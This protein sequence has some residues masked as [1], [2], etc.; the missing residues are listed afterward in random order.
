M[1]LQSS[2]IIVV[3]K[4]S[5]I[6]PNYSNNH[7]QQQFI[8]QLPQQQ[9]QQLQHQNLQINTNLNKTSSSILSSGSSTVV[10]RQQLT[11][12]TGIILPKQHL[13]T[14]TKQSQ[15]QKLRNL[16]NIG[17][18]KIISIQQ[19]I[20][21]T[22]VTATTITTT[23][24]LMRRN[25]RTISN[26]SSN[27]S[28]NIGASQQTITSLSSPSHQQQQQSS[29]TTKHIQFSSLNQQQTYNT[30]Q[31]SQQ[32]PQQTT[33]QHH[34]IQTA[35]GHPQ[36]IVS[37]EYLE[38]ATATG[39]AQIVNISANDL[40]NSQIIKLVSADGNG[41]NVLIDSL[42][43][44]TTTTSNSGNGSG[45]VTT[46]ANG[47]SKL[48]VGNL[49]LSSASPTTNINTNKGQQLTAAG[50][51]QQQINFV[52]AKQIPYLT[53]STTGNVTTKNQTIQKI[54]NIPLKA[55]NSV[56]GAQH[57]QQTFQ[58]GTNNQIIHQNPNT[59]GGTTNTTGQIIQKVNMP[60]NVHVVARVQTVSQQQQQQTQQ[61]Q[62]QTQNQLIMQQKYVHGVA[63]A[64]NKANNVNMIKKQTVNQ[65]KV[66]H[67]KISNVNLSGQQQQVKTFIHQ[68]PAQQNN[69]QFSTVI[70]QNIQPTTLTTTTKQLKTQQK[71]QQVQQ[72]QNQQIS[73][74]GTYTINNKISGLPIQQHQRIINT[75]GKNSLNQNTS[76]TKYVMQNHIV[77]PSN[78]NAANQQSNNNIA[79]NSTQPQKNNSN[80][81]N[82][83]SNSIV[84]NQQI[85]NTINN[86]HNNHN[87][88]NNLQHQQQLQ[89][90]SGTIKFV[91][92]HGT[93][94]QTHQQSTTTTV[95]A[96]NNPQQQTRL[97][98]Y[99][100]HQP[101]QNNQQQFLE[102]NNNNSNNNNNNNTNISGKSNPVNDNHV[103][104]QIQ[105]PTTT[106]LMNQPSTNSTVVLQGH[107]QQQRSQMNNTMSDNIV[108]VNGT[109]MTD[110]ESARILQSMAL[111]SYGNQRFQQQQQQQQTKIIQNSQIIQQQ[112][113]INSQSNQPPQGYVISREYQFT[114]N[115]QQQSSNQ[116]QQQ[117]QQQSQ[118]HQ[119]QSQQ[120]QGYAIQTTTARQSY[121]QSSGAS[122][123]SQ[124]I[125]ERKRERES[126]AAAAAAVAAANAA[127]VAATVSVSQATTQSTSTTNTSEFFK[128]K[129]DNTPAAQ[130]AEHDDD[131][132]GEEVRPIPIS[133]HD[134]VLQRL[135]AVL[136]DHTYHVPMPSP[137]PSEIM[138]TNEIISPLA[139]VVT[140]LSASG[141][142]TVT[143]TTAAINAAQNNGNGAVIGVNA[144]PNNGSQQSIIS[145]CSSV[146]NS[147]ISQIQTSQYSSQQ[148]QHQQQQQ[149]QIINNNDGLVSNNNNDKIFVTSG[150]NLIGQNIGILSNSPSVTSNNNST[151]LIGNIVQLKNNNSGKN[152]PNSLTNIAGP[153]NSSSYSSQSVGQQSHQADDD[154]NSVI[155]NESNHGGQGRL[156]M[157]LGEET[158]TAPEA[159][160][161]DDSVTRCI[162]D[163]THDDGYM[164]CCDKCFTW[165]HVDCMG[166]DRTNIPEEYLCEICQPRQVDKARARSL[167]LVKR[168]EQQAALLSNMQFNATNGANNLNVVSN[169]LQDGQNVPQ[170]VPPE[171]VKSGKKGKPKKS[172]LLKKTNAKKERV[173]KRKETKRVNKRKSKAHDFKTID[174][175]A[176]NLRQWIENYE[177][178][179]TNHYSPEL[180]ARLQ[181]IAKQ[182]SFLQAI[183]AHE[184]KWLRNYYGKF[185]MDSK[186]TVI[187]HA[188]GKILISNMDI[189]P[190]SPII[191]LRGKYMLTTQFKT[192]NPA[193]NMNSPPPLLI[194]AS[195][196][197]RTPGPFI[198]FYQLPVDS[199]SLVA[200]SGANS[201]RGI[202]ALAAAA[203]VT[204]ANGL[205]T[206]ICVDTRT[207]GNEARFV[208][209][210][211]RPNAE[212]QYSFEKGAIH[213]FIVSLSNI[214]SSTEITIRHEPHDLLALENKNSSQNLYI[215][216]T[217]TICA[218]GLTKDCAFGQL[219]QLPT[220]LSEPSP[221]SAKKKSKK[222]LLNG[223]LSSKTR[224]GV[225]KGKKI[226]NVSA[227]RARSISSSGESQNEILSPN[228]SSNNIN[229]TVITTN[230]NNSEGLTMIAN[231]NI[232]KSTEESLRYIQESLVYSAPVNTSPAQILSSGA[233]AISQSQI[234]QQTIMSP[235]TSL[236]T[237]VSPQQLPP[238]LQGIP[239]IIQPILQQKTQQ[240][241]SPLSLA[242]PQQT[243]QMIISQI[244][245]QD[246]N[247][248]PVSIAASQQVQHVVQILPSP[249]LSSPNCVSQQPSVVQ[250]ITHPQIEVPDTRQSIESN[251]NQFVKNDDGSV[252]NIGKDRQDIP[253]QT[254]SDDKIKQI[255]ADPP[256][257][258]ELK[259][260]YSQKSQNNKVLTPENE[261]QSKNLESENRTIQ[262][263]NSVTTADKINNS[264]ISLPQNTILNKIVMN[265]D[266]SNKKIN[267]NIM[268]N[269]NCNSENSNNIIDKNM[270][271]IETQDNTNDILSDK[272]NAVNKSNTNFQSNIH[273]N[274]SPI[275]NNNTSC[276]NNNNIATDQVD[277]PSTNNKLCNTSDTST[278]T[279]VS[280]QKGHVRKFSKSRTTSASEDNV[281]PNI[282]VD[283]TNSSSSTEPN[284][285]ESRK[286]TREERK[287]EAIVRAIEKMEKN[288]QRKN[289]LKNAK[290]IK[291][292][293]SSS[294]QSPKRAKTC[295][296]SE[297]G[298][299][300]DKNASTPIAKTVNKKPS[301]RKK[302][303]KGNRSYAM[304][305]AT[306][307]KRRRSRLNSNES[308]GNTSDDSPSVKSPSI[309]S[310]QTLSNMN[311]CNEQNS[312]VFSAP[313]PQYQQHN[314]LQNDQQNQMTLMTDLIQS[315]SQMQQ[316]KLQT[317]ET[318]SSNQDAGL[319]LAFANIEK[320]SEEPGLKS[321]PKRQS[322]NSTDL[323]SPQTP[324]PAISSACLLIESALGPLEGLHNDESSDSFKIPSKTAKTKKSLMS[325]WLN[326]SSDD[327]EIQLS[328]NKSHSE[329]NCII[330]NSHVGGNTSVIHF[331]QNSPKGFETL[332]QAAMVDYKPPIAVNSLSFIPPPSNLLQQQQMQIV[333]QP[334]LAS[335]GE[336]KCED[337][338]ENLC[339][340]AKKVEEFI[341]QNDY[342][343]SQGI[344]YL[345][346]SSNI[347]LI[348]DTDS[349]SSIASFPPENQP[350][351]N[352]CS[353]SA[354]KK[355]WLRQA[356][357]EE[358]DEHQNLL[359]SGSNSPTSQ[360][361]PNGFTTPLK[362]RRLVVVKNEQSTTYTEEMVCGNGTSE[363][364]NLSKTGSDSS[365]SNDEYKTIKAE[366]SEHGEFKEELQSEIKGNEDTEEEIKNELKAI[367]SNSVDNDVDIVGF[368]SPSRKLNI[369]ENYNL[370]KIEPE[371]TNKDIKIDIEKE[372]TLPSPTANNDSKIELKLEPKS[373][374]NISVD[375]TDN[376]N[377][378]DIKTKIQEEES[379]F[380]KEHSFENLLQNKLLK[381]PKEETQ[382]N[383]SPK[384][385]LNRKQTKNS[386]RV[387]CKPSKKPNTPVTNENKDIPSPELEKN[388]NLTII[389]GNNNAKNV[390]EPLQLDELADIQ[391]TL[392]SFHTEN[393]MLLQS[394]NKKTKKIDL[395]G[396][397][398]E[399]HNFKKEKIS[400]KS[401]LKSSKR[402]KSSKKDK[403]NKK[404]DKEDTYNKPNKHDASSNK[405]KLEYDN[406]NNIEHKIP[407]NEDISGSK[408]I[409][410]EENL[411]KTS[412]IPTSKY[413]TTIQD[414]T[415]LTP[416]VQNPLK[417]NSNVLQHL[418]KPEMMQ[419]S[420]LNIQNVPSCV[421]SNSTEYG[422]QSALSQYSFSS[423]T[424]QQQINPL[425][426]NLTQTNSSTQINSQ[427]GLNIPYYNTIYGKLLDPAK[428]TMAPVSTV[429]VPVGN[430][431][432]NSP[433]VS[434]ST[435]MLLSD[436]KSYS[437]LGAYVTSSTSFLGTSSI[438][439]SVALNM[440]SV[441]TSN[442]NNNTGKSA[443]T[444]S[445]LLDIGV[446]KI[447]TKTASHDP[448]LNPQLTIP[449]P[450]P[451]P[452]R[453]LSINE[454]RKRKQQSTETT[455]NS[456]D[457]SDSNSSNMGGKKTESFDDQVSDPTKVQF[458]PA[459]TLLEKQQEILCERLKTLK[460]Q[461][462]LAGNVTPAT[463]S[464]S[465]SINNNNNIVVIGGD[466]GGN[467]AFTN[468]LVTTA[469]STTTDS[470]LITN[471]VINPIDGNARTISTMSS[472]DTSSLVTNKNL[473]NNN[474]E[475]N[476]KTKLDHCT[477]IR[478][479]FSSF[480][481]STNDSLSPSSSPPSSVT[482]TPS[483]PSSITGANQDDNNISGDLKDSLNVTVDKLEQK[484]SKLLHRNRKLSIQDCEDDNK[485]NNN[486]ILSTNKQIL[487]NEIVDS[488]KSNNDH[489]SKDF[490]NK[491]KMTSSN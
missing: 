257:M 20:N 260:Q 94:L 109:K 392:H 484:K 474:K 268:E 164:I 385:N 209:R 75:T 304:H 447:I 431:Y 57:Q 366:A 88:S 156:E 455:T 269:T 214:M 432:Q 175:N 224:A 65:M 444:N 433:T 382:I 91:N 243:Q 319:L 308:D 100:Q 341:I 415:V 4:T 336:M 353:N 188:G 300:D 251:T 85:I 469:T 393:I 459:P 468:T 1:P 270:N 330:R 449:E 422:T 487:E 29:T 287:M 7:Q 456:I 220:L 321:S 108:I 372:E 383:D 137:L 129:G 89:P 340:A 472:T 486:N 242:S 236:Q 347:Q 131:I 198:F 280:P 202:A 74:S 135:H 84:V 50:Q 328:E 282:S 396:S 332:V 72:P 448:R 71:Q 122:N 273:G 22:P 296:Q 195:K 362:K 111:K 303:R 218:C 381:N 105:Q 143:I 281:T 389:S 8:Q 424:P 151:N 16:N 183:N 302:K 426:S 43:N 136:Q 30:N 461:K 27:S 112:H 438:V 348:R 434:Q 488:A 371:D 401:D 413:V 419:T 223:T 325:E 345:P 293:N 369:E 95:V 110:E 364:I 343:S 457:N 261:N 323:K 286:L 128:V 397:T 271:N 490:I 113:Q 440:G 67:H 316:N 46:G 370:I 98:A 124:T 96:A 380:K 485:N 331:P 363:D 159:E 163:L 292:R 234:I 204:S 170:A 68:Q 408:F 47:N 338:P 150:G 138:T 69:T 19:T 465:T 36:V 355:R 481:D 278:P 39:A 410:S 241:M 179:V 421:V 290:T 315:Q 409:G 187:P 299:E 5:V 312:E 384:F 240:H 158:E 324:T 277:S 314:M 165:Q 40:L 205:A 180:R 423:S 388:S 77:I 11:N 166:I 203:A 48:L 437:T 451:V 237:P 118:Q 458:S 231:N 360:Q 436:Y 391:K 212:L 288:Q 119:P 207:Y 248:Q 238:Q 230:P 62:Q 190:N 446:S 483:S 387:N 411:N 266:Q 87:N 226:H 162:C 228:S 443:N 133:T 399:K 49:V 83:L 313:H 106:F 146:Q 184:N 379:S 45:G 222:N 245:Q 367:D 310:R 167:Q 404:R 452:K 284:K 34:I 491:N 32:Q 374:N 142:S 263:Q 326:Q 215:A 9:Q 145:N 157:D 294:P 171:H 249:G 405:E 181:A 54:V 42:G 400:T 78:G 161:E 93:V 18:D 33:T 66:Q 412:S 13:G 265:K 176:D 425:G 361:V 130:Q 247:I 126:K 51:P 216:P 342:S 428:T 394:R 258:I 149:G 346:N 378:C 26:S 418:S 200:V 172:E 463:L 141:T 333:N 482:S 17:D 194:T 298:G 427:S 253:A 10:Q 309:T 121:N 211:C 233:T 402:E 155:S 213:L 44:V 92:A 144:S 359:T 174:K 115:Q 139:T 134:T 185:D 256:Q 466:G 403:N 317:L 101:Q 373:E 470:D 311:N 3:D 464:T 15:S 377:K 398:K 297:D 390:N 132:I 103:L 59:A 429:L 227:S 90:Q 255:Q 114:S 123:R 173:Q 2:G 81:N 291:R 53:A 31:M 320:T 154:A 12:S 221:T 305:A 279:K 120:Y 289:E 439:T 168:K 219:P 191:E 252:I 357:S 334:I 274:T 442:N 478:S 407:S 148:Q 376:E 295:S 64:P 99:N 350:L 239:T 344:E 28:I 25:Q 445:S 41:Q 272:R 152:L 329:A 250:L 38:H 358:T 335:N 217:S 102:S 435:N 56:K 73:S 283:Q 6:P 262:T 307:R 82:A 351:L 462:N 35:G 473:I 169:S 178:A 24:N 177:V 107:Q 267:K 232:N 201:S 337:I 264:T 189:L 104:Y 197:N 322:R 368:S 58:V 354:A 229:T 192:Q 60:R 441:I 208:R 352:T 61:Q 386:S 375:V 349:P 479:S 210:S 420:Y 140:S 416:S 55:S 196:N 339:L 467:D 127:A 76:T 199:A 430:Q 365:L 86:S 225:K 80:L 125:S 254:V 206:E 480:N 301:I 63:A 37:E 23:K 395:E 285:R 14:I 244:Q 117:Q 160:A 21:N 193:L 417:V 477:S 318:N 153:L 276:I 306:Q 79:T 182:P 147:I 453:K 235:N 259:F 471:S 186:G 460:Q 116:Q 70:N 356:I 454:Y 489:K 450:T 97:R 476:K 275:L 246:K 327:Q 475:I 406:S 52:S 414:Q